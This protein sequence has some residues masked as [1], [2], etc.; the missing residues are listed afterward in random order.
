MKWLLPH[1]RVAALGMLPVLLLAVLAYAPVLR[2]DFVGFDDNLYVSANRIVQQGLTWSGLR[3]AFT[4]TYASTWQPLVWL[5]YM[6]DV[7]LQGFHPASFHRTNLLLHLIHVMLVWLAIRKLTRSS[8]AATTTSLLLAL[9]P[10][11]VESVAWIAERKGLLS[12]IF[13]WLAIWAYLNF[14]R[15]GQHR[16]Y[17]LSLVAMTLGLMAKPVVLTLPLI[18]LLLDVWPLQRMAAKPPPAVWIC[19]LREKIPFLLLA[20]ISTVVTIHA[21]HRGGSFLG[22]DTIPLWGR[23]GNAIVSICRYLW[24]LLVPIRLA[25][26]YP[27]PV[28]WPLWQVLAGMLLLLLAGCVVYRQRRQQPWPAWGAVWFLVI[29]SPVLGFNQF[30]WHA[31]ADRF[32]YLP[33]IGLYC[34]LGMTV[35]GIWQHHRRRVIAIGLAGSVGLAS[36]TYY[37][38]GYWRNSLTLFTRAVAVTRDNWVMLNSL[39]AALSHAGRH[40]EAATHFEQSLALHPGNAR[41]LFNLGH[42]RFLQERWEDAARLFAQSQQLSPQYQTLFNLAVTHARREA[43]EDAR[44]AYLQL[45]ESH[46]RHP[47]A[48]LNLGRI[49][50]ILQKPDQ[51]MACY[52]LVLETEPD[53]QIARTGAA[54]V[55]LEKG[56][57]PLGAIALLV[58]LLE[59]DPGN[60]EAREA[61]HAAIHGTDVPPADN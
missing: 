54:I 34:A 21:Q 17:G 55:M 26:F 49:Y 52:R 53:N 14:A 44:K 13:W 4:A 27:H 30:G 3:W 19:R 61:L 37:Q 28:T 59:D 25:V 31:M 8:V 1:L 38:A 33:A 45:L 57:N 23:F 15:T 2:A 22:L 42:V 36:L 51:A 18:L 20:V 43:Y 10:V 35:Q 58:R 11:H 6:L 60:A 41:A 32:L 5:S 50:R 16:Q 9:H 47:L 7:Q 48:L 39:G 29:L 12:A 40:D 56:E 46:P 24:H